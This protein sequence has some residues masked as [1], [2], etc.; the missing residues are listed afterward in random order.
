MTPK[1]RTRLRR[2][3][4]ALAL[5]VAVP[6]A[7]V[8]FIHS[9]PG[10]RFARGKIEQA[11]TGRM[12][13][14]RATIGDVT[15]S[16][17]SGVTLSSLS[18]N[19][20]DGREAVHVGLI[21]LVPHWSEILERRPTL[22]RLVVRD[23]RVAVRQSADGTSNLS[24]LFKPAVPGP[25]RKPLDRVAIEHL[26]V[27]GTQLS[28]QRPD[29]TLVSLEDGGVVGSV[30]ARPATS[31]VDLSLSR[32]GLSLGVKRPDGLE[33]GVRDLHWGLEAHL[34]RGAGP[35]TLRPLDAQLV[36]ALPS[37]SAPQKSQL[38]FGE[39]K[40]TLGEGELALA[41][42]QIAAAAVA[43]ESVSLS[44]KYVDGA[45]TGEQQASLVGL[46]VD[47]ARLHE[48][49]GKQVL[50]GD[51]DIGLKLAGR[52]DKLGVEAQV[53]SS[54]QRLALTGAID[55]HE[56]L[57]L[58]YDLSLRS[59]R[60]ALPELLVID[61]PPQVEARDIALAVKGHGVTRA[62]AS[63]DVGF[64]AGP[65]VVRGAPINRVE[66]DAHF[67]HGEIVLRKLRVLAVAQELEV[68]G[69]YRLSDGLIS[70]DI[71]SR[72]AL[73]PTI[74]RLR[75][76]G[77][78]VPPSP[79][80]SAL[81]LS[82]EG[83]RAHVEGSLDTMLR[84]DV[85][86]LRVGLAGGALQ[87]RAS[88]DL[89]A[90]DPSKGEKRVRARSL[91]ADVKVSGLPIGR[92]AALRG[93]E[94]PVDGAVSGEVKLR[95][96][97]ESPEATFDLRSAFTVPGAPSA[98]PMALALKGKAS[99]GRVTAHARVDEGA[100]GG[101]QA[102]VL[103]ADIDAPLA[104]R[105]ISL[106]AP[107]AI[108]IDIP[109]RPI[110]AIAELL[111][112]AIREKAKLPAHGDAEVHIDVKG[113]GAHPRGTVSVEASGELA[114]GGSQRVRVDATLG[115]AR[116]GGDGLQVG[117]RMAASAHG[118]SPSLQAKG[119]LHFARSPLLDRDAA[120]SW[121]TEIDVN[122]E[123]ASLP[124][125]PERKGL[126]GHV[127]AHIAASGNRQDL[128]AKIDF[129]GRGIARGGPPL[130]LDASVA[131]TPQATTLSASAKIAGVDALTVKGN[132][133]LGGKGLY[134]ALKER[135]DPRV[136]LEVDFP[137]H[138][139]TD[140]APAVAELGAL[141]GQF[142]GK[143]KLS[144]PA[145]GL[146]LDGE[147]SYSGYQTL[148]GKPGQLGIEL[149]GSLAGARLSL[150]VP[151]GLGFDAT[152]SPAAL[153]AARM[154]DKP[155]SVRAYLQMRGES[156]LA[157][158]LPDAPQLR[159]AGVA[160]KL[161]GDLAIEARLLVSKTSVEP[162]GGSFSGALSLDG[163]SVLIPD[164]RR[165]LHDLTLKLRGE[166]ETLLVEQLVAHESDAEKPDRKLTVAG[167]L[168]FD[169]LRLTG[170][171][172]R[173]RSEDFLLFGGSFGQID[174]PRASVTADIAVSADL[175]GGS[176]KIDVE[177][178]SFS[179]SSP[180]RFPKA[181]QPEVVSVGDLLEVSSASQ[182]G[183]LPVASGAARARGEGAAGKRIEPAPGDA[184]PGERDLTVHIRIPKPVRFRQMPLDLEATGDV[185]VVRTESGQRRVSGKLDAVGGRF[186]MGGKLLDL[187]HGSVAFGD[188]GSVVD[189]WFKREASPT[190]LRD[191]ATEDASSVRVHLDGEV[192]KQQIKVSGLTESLFGAL[193][194]LN[195]GRVRYLTRPDLP[196]SETPQLPQYGEIRESSYVAANLPHLLFLDRAGVI[197][198]PRDGRAAYGRLQRV[199]AER[200]FN[201]GSTRLK[202]RTRPPT[203]GVS[204]GEVEF[205]YLFTNTPRSVSGAGLLGGTRGGGGPTVFWEWSSAD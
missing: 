58:G 11:I 198:D 120:L 22:S 36:L 88:A 125:P 126:A 107:L 175:T 156:A 186:L 81:S 46:H 202:L 62:D 185:T 32:I 119:A 131:L 104:G 102:R 2:A 139:M 86:D 87:V 23:V 151:G 90:G 189:L 137:T 66:V 141:P 19:G 92:L 161:S 103:D 83:V 4:T 40:I 143:L 101:P 70:A 73:A 192:G 153:V 65:L 1:T 105:S 24:T 199:D 42:S 95:G 26:E 49:L 154:S 75:E 108:K 164:T 149:S 74:A 34:E 157:D 68:S 116:D 33:I 37:A 118:D 29:G 150:G 63:V 110:A 111:P 183:R 55:A 146:K 181:H 43:L 130:D 204:Q 52:P 31:G 99:R 113:S 60:L 82:K 173:V 195:L 135:P 196:A 197:A 13:G 8:A 188:K 54:G 155:S 61:N 48:L 39:T 127:K 9:G 117:Y 194:V 100:K 57:S 174:A 134:A 177:V 106:T 112:P 193:S 200:Y 69:K 159:E 115:P 94:A 142:G 47:R 109:K 123:L 20:A 178:A 79:L 18:L 128:E 91:E 27:S 16:V 148:S 76:A 145:T 180:D 167:K 182:I 176:R 179:L 5:L 190:A 132:I 7:G 93:R 6:A 168:S 187:D 122:E 30:V 97:P 80:L 78:K 28:L 64:T 17:F 89:V 53:A 50:A 170:A 147:F 201:Q 144:G 129:Q 160:G 205:D 165:K 158:L 172:G 85:P 25:G 21:E 166:D 203:V 15:L 67:E 14:G 41:S 59:E 71:A 35:I 56:R 169:K 72:G 163:A 162:S 171:Q 133:G 3:A 96:T 184:A 12:D 124:L 10:Q 44:G 98:K 114:P 45:L 121:D 191:F 152:I 136:S 140:W 38:A 77:V 138:E 84:I 51:I